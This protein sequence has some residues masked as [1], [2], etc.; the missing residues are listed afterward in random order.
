M[1]EVIEP[2]YF[3]GRPIHHQKVFFVAFVHR[4]KNWAKT[5]LKQQAS[6]AFA[7]FP[8]GILRLYSPRGRQPKL[9]VKGRK[10]FQPRLQERTGKLS[11]WT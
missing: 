7:L 5:W 10:V 3:E 11:G 4:L 2:V 6:C 9:E 1:K 8:R